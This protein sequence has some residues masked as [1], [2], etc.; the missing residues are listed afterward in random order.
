MIGRT[1][2]LP[3]TDV[4]VLRLGALLHDIGKIGVSDRILRKNGSLTAEGFEQIKR[5]PGRGASC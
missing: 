1:M 2:N 3:A 4:E 5:H